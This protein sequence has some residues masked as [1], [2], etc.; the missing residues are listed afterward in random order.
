MDNLYFAVEAASDGM[1]FTE[2]GQV[3]RRPAQP[4]FSKYQFEHKKILTAVTFYRVNR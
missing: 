1:N 2:V 4:A 3:K